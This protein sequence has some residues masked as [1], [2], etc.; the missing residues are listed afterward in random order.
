[1]FVCYQGKG[2]GEKVRIM[3]CCEFIGECS[4]NLLFSFGV[5]LTPF[6][7]PDWRKTVKNGVFVKMK[8]ERGEMDKTVVL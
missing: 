3:K 2:D 7:T 8:D 5:I 1:M 4:K 6:L